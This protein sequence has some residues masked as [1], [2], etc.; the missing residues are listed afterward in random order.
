MNLFEFA[1]CWGHFLVSDNFRMLTLNARVAQLLIGMIGVGAGA[2]DL[3]EQRGCGSGRGI[4][5]GAWL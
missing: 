1:G 5:G 4:A 2:G 3:V